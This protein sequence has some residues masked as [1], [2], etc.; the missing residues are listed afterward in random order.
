MRNLL[1][2]TALAAVGVLAGARAAN[3]ADS[4]LMLRDDRPAHDEAESLLVGN[5]RAGRWCT[6][7]FAPKSKRN[8]PHSHPTPSLPTADQS[9]AVGREHVLTFSTTAGQIY[10]IT[11]AR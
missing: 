7:A 8:S 5:G 11:A 3:Q 9:L 2:S 6:A 10:R 4:R 1:R